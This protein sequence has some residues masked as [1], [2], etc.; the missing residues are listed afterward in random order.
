MSE[1]TQ[2]WVPEEVSIRRRDDGDWDLVAVVAL[3]TGFRGEVK[4]IID[5]A[6]LSLTVTDHS[7]HSSPIAAFVSNHRLS[8]NSSLS[9]D[10]DGHKLRMKILQ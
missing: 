4:M 3:D 6:S 9:T 8:L 2:V 10:E 5:D 7:P 1:V